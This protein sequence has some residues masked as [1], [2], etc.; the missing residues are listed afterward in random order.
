MEIL[1]YENE[2]FPKPYS[3]NIAGEALVISYQ[4]DGQLDNVCEFVSR[5]MGRKFFF[6][7]EVARILDSMTF[8]KLLLTPSGFGFING[9]TVYF[10][11]FEMILY[12]KEP[13]YWSHYQELPFTPQCLF[14]NFLISEKKIYG[15]RE[16]VKIVLFKEN[17]C[18][19][20]VSWKIT[21]AGKIHGSVKNERF[22]SILT[23]AV[24]VEKTLDTTAFRKLV[25]LELKEYLGINRKKPDEYETP[26]FK[27]ISA[28]GKKFTLEMLYVLSGFSYTEL[29]AELQ[30]F[31]EL[32]YLETETPTFAVFEE[33]SASLATV[34]ASNV[35][36]YSNDKILFFEKVSY[37]QDISES[38]LEFIIKNLFDVVLLD[39]YSS[40]LD[41]WI[42]KLFY[43][44]GNFQFTLLE[45]STEELEKFPRKYRSCIASRILCSYKS[46]YNEL[47][48]YYEKIK[49]YLGVDDRFD[50]ESHMIK[51]FF[52][53]SEL[54]SI[55]FLMGKYNV[56]SKLLTLRKYGK[57]RRRLF[58]CYIRDELVK[59]FKS[60]T[61]PKRNRSLEETTELE[62]LIYSVLLRYVK[63]PEGVMD[64]LAPLLDYS[65]RGGITPSF[66][67]AVVCFMSLILQNSPDKELSGI[68]KNYVSKTLNSPE[69]YKKAAMAFI[70][71][72]FIE[73][74]YSP[75]RVIRSSLQKAQS[76]ALSEKD[77]QIYADITI[78]ISF[79]SLVSEIPLTE[80]LDEANT[81]ALLEKTFPEDMRK[82]HRM[83]ISFIEDLKK[84]DS[85]LL[86]NT[87]QPEDNNKE[88]GL[89]LFKSIRAI[90]YKEQDL[91]NQLVE[92]DMSQFKNNPTPTCFLIR[93]NLWFLKLFYCGGSSCLNFKMKLS[94]FIREL[95]TKA[96]NCPENFKVRYFLLHAGQL[97]NRGMTKEAIRELH[98][99]RNYS[100]KYNNL[101]MKGIVEEELARLYRGNYEKEK[102]QKFL[103]YAS[104]SYFIYGL[105]EKS[106]LLGIFEI[107]KKNL[108]KSSGKDAESE[109]FYISKLLEIVADGDK[110]DVLMK[111]KRLEN[112]AL[113]RIDSILRSS[114]KKSISV[115]I[116]K[117]PV[118][119]SFVSEL[120]ILSLITFIRKSMEK[121]DSTYQGS[122][123]MIDEEFFLKSIGLLIHD[124]I[125]QDVVSVKIGLS[126]DAVHSRTEMLNTS[127]DGIIRKLRGLSSIFYPHEN[128]PLQDELISAI[129]G[130]EDFYGM[131]IKK[132]LKIKREVRKEY[133][134]QI[135]SITRELLF[136]A[137]KHNLGMIHE[138]TLEVK[139]SLITDEEKLK[140]IVSDNG[141][142]CPDLG[143]S[144]IGLAG[145]TGRVSLLSGKLNKI[146]ETEGTEVRVLIYNDRLYPSLY[147]NEISSLS[148]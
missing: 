28:V 48:L 91:I 33:C 7:Y 80:V 137:V 50:V 105:D 23:A 135:K 42:E 67:F 25:D 64:F 142:G 10:D 139:I 70:F 41:L 90:I 108:N 141:V 121:S 68:I 30:M 61:L 144:G 39:K 2:Y 83:M 143:K 85:S 19:E 140:I 112:D 52:D 106:E 24:E 97:L 62:L 147:A 76:I 134:Y 109:L 51:H 138:K 75:F 1:S 60:S 63:D 98:R 26:L 29:I 133:I 129:S 53:R 12:S 49:P 88:L 36:V 93:C 136:N 116:G 120:R 11:L 22:V 127:L 38:S 18:K 114:R 107:T 5:S 128:L 58:I 40:T 34:F 31:V 69:T 6:F 46:G 113:S 32:G 47:P 66:H 89:I 56:H 81:I 103:N 15:L 16:L 118:E 77:T 71:N 4:I 96:E 37:K 54:S 100:K 92:I 130:I 131:E 13:F 101:L 8:E 78:V 94:L 27:F 115:P 111:I 82:L 132:H 146:S 119:G 117:T 45:L 145:V 122:F 99:A 3:F 17:H 86:I 59:I 21:N 110:N 72:H 126:L 95:K 124:E 74:K 55:D 123:S 125:I 148:E 79:Y 65:I 9:K 14:E 102:S 43:K 104:E 35:E 84:K 73:H 20:N 57:I 87:G 44:E